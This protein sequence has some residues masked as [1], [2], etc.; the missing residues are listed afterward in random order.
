MKQLSDLTAWSHF[1]AVVNNQIVIGRKVNDDVAMCQNFSS[2]DKDWIAPV[3]FG[4]TYFP[5]DS[6]SQDE[7][8]NFKL[9]GWFNEKFYR[10]YDRYDNLLKAA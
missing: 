10:E 7:I 6:L 1:K 8:T 9:D 2:N 5:I 3:N 4:K